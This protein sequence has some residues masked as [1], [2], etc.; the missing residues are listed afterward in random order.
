M[1]LPLR[2]SVLICL[3]YAVFIDFI[4]VNLGA[5][6]KRTDGVEVV[7]F[8]V[9]LRSFHSYHDAVFCEV[10]TLVIV[11]YANVPPVGQHC[12]PKVEPPNVVV[13][14]PAVFSV[15]FVSKKYYTPSMVACYNG[16]TC[17]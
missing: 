16:G 1:G 14:V 17:H 6:R 5:D 8:A 3:S 4:A 7:P 2:Y 13:L 9:V 11:V 10:I 12:I 15:P